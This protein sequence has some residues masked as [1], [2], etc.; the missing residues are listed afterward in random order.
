MGTQ[1]PD[2]MSVHT[3][4]A[5]RGKFTTYAYHKPRT[6]S[7]LNVPD[8]YPQ[9]FTD[10]R[11]HTYHDEVSGRASSTGK[12]QG[13]SVPCWEFRPYMCTRACAYLVTH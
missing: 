7:T 8:F 4:H 9:S 11:T 13:V 10:H 12:T 3:C 1:E 2:S 5:S 6:L